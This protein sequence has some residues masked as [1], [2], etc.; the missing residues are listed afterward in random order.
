VTPPTSWPGCEPICAGS[1]AVSA[2]DPYMSPLFRER[3]SVESN[4]AV[5]PA[6]AGRE[7]RNLL[8]DYYDRLPAVADA[9]SRIPGMMTD[10]GDFSPGLA[11]P[12]LDDPMRAF[13]SGA[14]VQ[15]QPLG[16]YRDCRLT[17]L[18]LARNPGTHTTKTFA[19]LLIVARA[20]EHIRRTGESVLLFSP[21]SANKGTAL[22]DAVLRALDCGLVEREQLRIAVLAPRSA[23]G[24]LRSTE[25]SRDPELAALN[26][27]LC[28]STPEAEQV[29][30]LGRK[31]ADAYAA[32]LKSS[33]TRLWFSLR[34]GNYMLADAARAFVEQD[35]D[36][37]S[38]SRPRYHAHAVSSAFGL[39]GYHFGRG[40]LEAAGEASPRTRP[41]SLLVQHLGTPDMVLSLTKGGFDAERP[42]YRF[43]PESGLYHQTQDPTF[44]Y[45]TADPEELL[46]PTF[47]TH[48]PATSADMNQII[49]QHGGSGIVVSL[50]ECLDAYPALRHRL[51]EY[52]RQPPADPRKLREWSLVMAYT[53]ACNAVDRG[54]IP[55]GTDIV[56]HGSGWYTDADY[57]PVTQSEVVPVS[58]PAEIA[59]AV[60]GV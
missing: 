45:K 53:G 28:Y 30:A 3:K 43:D 32:D 21:T 51:E 10:P 19:S 44:P 7:E 18:D 15:W 58:D 14:S 12:E 29:K 34:L 22:R 60:M 8:L 57:E 17:L 49:G 48:R 37:A 27:L 38:A 40:L 50:N 59:D 23:M 11:L 1:R 9:L 52:D 20:V 47:Y 31:F 16:T 26:P 6:A 42:A 5:A 25:L 4:P 13:L 41:S 36:P 33:G 56:I 35:V 46:E 24:K 39:L 2:T 54:V 55:A